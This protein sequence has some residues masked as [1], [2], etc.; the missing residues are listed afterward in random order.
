MFNTIIDLIKNITGK[1]DLVLT[2]DTSFKNNIGFNSYEL[3]Q[4]IGMIED[5]FNITVP[6]K[7][8]KELKTIKNVI[9]YIDEQ[10][11]KANE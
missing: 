5:E 2:E 7:K 8:V 9:D 1:N 4:F 3:M 10:E 11:D 6:I